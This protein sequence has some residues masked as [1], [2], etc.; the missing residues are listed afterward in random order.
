M[1]VLEQMRSGSDSTFMQVVVV[2]VIVAFV[3]FYVRPQGERSGV[4]ATVNGTR[5]MD[6][7]RDRMYRNELMAAERRQNRTL[8]DDEQKQLQEQVR[9]QLIEQE[10][11]A[12]EAEDLGLE[13]SDE[14]VA[15]QIL[16]MF[17]DTDGEF[18]KK[19]YQR[20]LKMRQ[21]TE[22]SF[23]ERVRRDL[24]LEKLQSLAFMGASL[25]E[26]ALREAYIEQ[27]T[28]VQLD[29]VEVNPSV[30]EG[31]VT[32]TDEERARWVEANEARIK[33]VYDR[34]FKRLYEHPEQVRLSL[35]RLAVT[36]EGPGVAELVPKLAKIREEIEGGAAFATMAR[37]WSEDPSALSGGD[38]GMRPVQ[39]LSLKVSEEIEGL[40]AGS[41]TK[42]FTTENDVRLLRVEERKERYEESLDDVRGDIADRLIREERVPALALAFAE[43]ELLPAW[44]AA[45]SPPQD[46]LDARALRVR[47]TGMVSTQRGE[48]LFAPPQVLLDAARTAEAGAVIDDVFEQ[49]NVLYVAQL[50]EREDPDMEAFEEEKE[51]IREGLLFSRRQEFFDDWVAALKA[52]S[53]IR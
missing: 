29:L 34:D 3:G 27:E 38:L 14:E 18:S 28:K 49:S 20:F 48:G 17:R 33:E 42:V 41:L 4:V 37:R 50:T 16:R 2:L 47:S 9:Q 15:R 43:E 7:E 40:G 6:T 39:Q 26:P 22:A 36:G 25:S 10:I 46:L 44:K 23:Q 8:S 11:L 21:F 31:D 51:Q 35:I 52:E 5:I 1:G 13:V 24:T 53:T 30:F 45:G 19:N 32:V 12:Q